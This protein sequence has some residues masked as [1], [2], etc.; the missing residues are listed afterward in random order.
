MD[1]RSVQLTLGHAGL[2]TTQRY[3]HVRDEK[4]LENIRTA[5]EGDGDRVDQ[6]TGNLLRRGER[7]FPVIVTAWDARFEPG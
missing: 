2:A 6:A 1:I 5:L 7:R 3:L 4:F